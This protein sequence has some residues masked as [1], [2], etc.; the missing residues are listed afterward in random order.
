MDY[1]MPSGLWGRFDFWVSCCAFCIRL[2]YRSKKICVIFSEGDNFF[3]FRRKL[4][5]HNWHLLVSKMYVICSATAIILEI[6]A[7]CKPALWDYLVW[8]THP[9]QSETENSQESLEMANRFHFPADRNILGNKMSYREPERSGLCFFLFFWKTKKSSAS[10]LSITVFVIVWWKQAL[11]QKLLQ[12]WKPIPCSQLLSHIDLTGTED[13][14][15]KSTNS[16]YWSV[17]SFHEETFSSL[18]EWLLLETRT[19]FFFF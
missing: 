2:Y 7:S 15:Y 12:N 13:G 18:V 19:T 11:R 8:N 6:A 14:E 3:S 5:K 1:W 17:S 4:S 10:F 16:E 9:S